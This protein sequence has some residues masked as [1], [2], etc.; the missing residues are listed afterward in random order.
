MDTLPLILLGVGA[1][2]VWSGAT[3]RRA[4]DVIK[5]ILRTGK[6]GDTMSQK[7]K[8]KKDFEELDEMDKCIA[9]KK[10]QGMSD[11]EARKACLNEQDDGKGPTGDICDLNPDLPDCKGYGGGGGVPASTNG[12]LGLGN[13]ARKL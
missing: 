11:K 10:K 7:A 6:P 1:L 3:D 13:G 4:D 8:E 2:L 9:A 12:G 5:S